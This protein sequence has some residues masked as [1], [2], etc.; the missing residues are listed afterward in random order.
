[1]INRSSR[2]KKKEKNVMKDLLRKKELDQGTEEGTDMGRE[3]ATTMVT[4]WKAEVVY[5][6]GTLEG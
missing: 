1:M 3:R 2:G 5:E 4:T 6:E